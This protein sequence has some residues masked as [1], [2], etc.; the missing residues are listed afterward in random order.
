M[1]RDNN[2]RFTKQEELSTKQLNM[3]S[4]LV[5]NGGNKTKACKKLSVPRSTLYKWFESE[6]FYNEYKKR[7]DT[8]INSSLAKALNK[9]DKSLDSKDARTVL[10]AAENILKLNGYLAAKVDINENT[11]ENFIITL[12]NETEEDE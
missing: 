6:I 9:L 1:S 11:T 5:L 7:C 10:K 12:I 4:E 8:F 3:I 2:G